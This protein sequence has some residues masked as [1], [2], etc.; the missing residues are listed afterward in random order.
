MKVNFFC[1]L[2][3]YLIFIAASFNVSIPAQTTVVD[4]K[5]LDVNGNPSKYALVGVASTNYTNAEFFN[6][7]DDKGNYSIKLTQ[8]G[9]NYVVFTIPSHQFL[10]IP[11]QNIKNKKLT[12][13]VKLAPYKYK[14]NF[15]NVGVQGPFNNYNIKSPDKMTKRK[16]GTYILEVKSSKKEI[17]YELCGI[18]KNGRTINA[19]GSYKYEPDSSGDYWSFEKVTDGQAVIVFD[20]S[21]LL[22]EG[23]EY[24]VVFK[25]SKFDE[26]VFRINN[27]I[28]NIQLDASQKMRAYYNLEKD[29][30]NFKYDKGNYFEQ[31][32]KKINSEKDKELK[33]Y[34]KLAYVSFTVYKPKNYDLGKAKSFF[35]SIPPEN[36]AWTIIPASYNSVYSIFP[37]PKQ[38]EILNK[39][40]KQ[41]NNTQI[42]VFI[43]ASRLSK[44]KYSNDTEEIKR[45]HN[46]I[47]TDYKDL[48][49]AQNLLKAFPINP[50]IN[51]GKEIPDF[52]VTSIDD[53][54]KVYSK[55]SMM[56]KIYMIDFWATWCSPCIGEMENLHKAYEKFRKKG[57]D[58]LSF[59]L[60]SNPETVESFRK[61]KWQM[62]WKNSFIGNINGR[63]IADEFEVTGIPKPILVSAEGKI[64]AMENE[65]R[66]RELEKTLSKYFE[67]K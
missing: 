18:E 24:K 22:R 8:P 33:N 29:V 44:A 50:K 31:L 51:I 35:E 59:S 5:L 43:L 13:D 53:S 25:G 46:L 55:K 7:C 42:K 57:F 9:Q 30:K 16:D 64:L 52:K 58:I 12:I 23:K 15:E 36:Y 39:F 49:E 40:L 48:K 60:D 4:G 54:T 20:P 41:C 56:G 65:L 11:V 2:I 17:R 27:Q 66:G 26:T 3:K 34:L 28:S 6:K 37:E 10:K 45:I 1:K 67:T 63:K 19:P 47:L 14:E 38:K 32:L 21:K 61:N 62:P